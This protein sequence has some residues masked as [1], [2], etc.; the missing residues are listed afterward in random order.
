M[1]LAV[2]AGK[3]ADAADDSRFWICCTTQAAYQL[4]KQFK[5]DN[6]VIPAGQWAVDVRWFKRVKEVDAGA[7]YKSLGGASG[8]T[9]PLDCCLKAGRFDWGSVSS[10]GKRA[11]LLEETAEM[12]EEQWAIEMLDSSKTKTSR[13]RK[14][15]KEAKGASKKKSAGPQMHSS[16]F[17]DLVSHCRSFGSGSTTTSSTNNSNHQ[18]NQQFR[19]NGSR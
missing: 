15:P 2:A 3:A 10:C 14:S 18:F 9:L 4:K 7:Q 16:W 17:V 19:D 11:V 6:L 8:C 12:L 1:L 13:K 5:E